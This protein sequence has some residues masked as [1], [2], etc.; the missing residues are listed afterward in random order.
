MKPNFLRLPALA[1][2]LVGILW[3]DEYT[4]TRS[5]LQIRR[6]NG[7]RCCIKKTVIFSIGQKMQYENMLQHWSLKNIVL[8]RSYLD[9][10][11]MH[12]FYWLTGWET[13]VF[14]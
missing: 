11:K 13:S 12:G 5:G 1:V 7:S 4:V 14:A 10:C 6:I 2:W 8:V 9:L 3:T